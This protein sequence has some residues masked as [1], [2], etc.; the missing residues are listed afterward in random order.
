MADI[1]IIAEV[2][3]GKDI[4]SLINSTSRLESRVKKLGSALNK[5]KINQTQYNQGLKEATR[6][7]T[8][9]YKTHQ[10][11]SAVVR[12][13][14]ADYQKATKEQE[15]AIA[16]A[17]REK[18]AVQDFARARRE[19]TAENA[20]FD[21]ERRKQIAL[22]EQAAATEERLRHKFQAGYT[23][24]D[25]YSKEMNDLAVAR[26][27]DIISL[28]EQTKAVQRLNL[29]MKK[30]TGRFSDNALAA[31]R[32]TRSVNRFGLLA[33]QSGYQIGDFLVQVQSGTNWMVAFGQQATQVAGTLTLLGGKF[34]LI[35]SALGIIIPLVTALGAAWMRTRQE[36]DDASDSVSEMESA[37]G[38][39]RNEISDI[40]QELRLLQSGFQ[41]TFQLTFR[42]SIKMA[43]D[44]LALAKEDLAELTALEA[45]TRAM[46]GALPIIGDRI[47]SADRDAVEAAEERVRL[48]EAELVAA[49]AIFGLKQAT[50]ESRNQE[51]SDAEN[52]VA[53]LQRQ[54]YEQQQL[55]GLQGDALRVAEEKLEMQEL[56]QELLEAGVE[57]MSDL[58][59][60]AVRLLQVMQGNAAAA[61]RLEGSLD[62]ASRI[63]FSNLPFA[64][65][66]EATRQLEIYGQYQDT[67]S[68]AP[69][70]PVVHN[71]PSRS[72]GGGGGGGGGPSGPTAL[73][74]LQKEV[75]E[76]RTLLTLYGQQRMLQEEIYDVTK[77]L[78]DEAG[79]MS[80]Q[81][82]EDLAK[83]NLEL[84]KQE[85]LYAQR[86]ADVQSIADTM[87]QSM[88]DA[89]TSMVEGTKSFKDAIRDMA[90]AVVKQLWDIF[91]IQRLIGGFDS[92]AGTGT[93]L[94][95]R[96]FG[97]LA[98]ADGNA[99]S[100]G[101]VTAFADGGVVNSPTFFPMANGMGLM[102]EAGPEAV[103]P[104]KR[105]KNGKLGVQTEGGQGNVVVNQTFAFSANG[106]D[107]VKKIIAEQAP[108]IAAL[109][110]KTMMDSR[111]RGGVTRAT[112][113]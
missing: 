83:I 110:Q 73:E 28:E 49:E 94:V 15:R 77:K 34:I 16:V 44:E 4:E 63:T 51:V 99:F 84:D 1:Q 106:D 69:D 90:R 59:N 96:I 107:S 55:F 46:F 70:T 32:S 60:M 50:N 80:A 85:E 21:A 104:L 61:E 45:G 52:I 36:S 22:A 27:L 112:F 66:M 43:R 31:H 91:V 57:P 68:A 5:G 8:P 89:F 111:R 103:M 109:T 97:F 29:E 102:G 54:V 88:G 12:K 10:K 64:E 113:G 65:G 79:S 108:K 13:L 20:R 19:A 76:R 72:S 87:S 75:E 71:T 40:R 38:S 58:W 39:A 6:A 53:N 56:Y 25:V 11:A 81:Q 3:G 78:G 18:L 74:R 67:R 7:A 23:A 37:L 105:G 95:G 41:E 2:I 62:R 48:A 47:T 100:N 86:L 26:K 93:G 82:I 42:D 35:G 30:G 33:Q 17:K 14:A 24:M 101:K 9:L 92:T 98:N